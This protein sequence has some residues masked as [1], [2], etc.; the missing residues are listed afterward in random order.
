ME[1]QAKMEKAEALQKVN[2]LKQATIDFKNDHNIQFQQTIQA[3]LVMQEVDDRFAGM[4]EAEVKQAEELMDPDTHLKQNQVNKKSHWR[5]IK[6]VVENCEVVLYVLDARDPMGS[7][8]SEV[9]ELIAEGNTK[10]LYIMNKKDLV[11]EE[12]VK[13]WVAKFKEDKRIL[14]PFQSNL[15]V[16]NKKVDEEEI[17]T[18]NGS[19]KLLKLL[20]KYAQKFAEKKETTYISAGVIGYPNTGKSSLINVLRNKPL[21]ATGNSPFITRSIQEVKVNSAVVA[22]DTPSVILSKVINEN[23][24]ETIRSV[25]QVDEIKNPVIIAEQILAKVGKEEILRHYRIAMFDS[26]E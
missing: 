14:V 9:E 15:T 24:L 20:F 8:N 26:T 17:Q 12:N 23:S 16:F 18:T 19:E 3:P 7:I 1:A 10:V 21:C 25:V 2:N 6:K 13:E 11:P 4:T 5:D 22:Y